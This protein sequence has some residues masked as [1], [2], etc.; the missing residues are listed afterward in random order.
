MVATSRSILVAGGAG[1]IGSHV[2]KA[3]AGRGF[4]P[5]TYDNLC[6]GNRWA[7]RWGPL[8]EGDIGDASLLGDTLRRYEI[9]GAIHLAAFA[10]VGE[11]VVAPERYFENNVSKALVFLDTLRRHGVKHLVFSST[12]ATYG[13]PERVPIVET[14][15]QRPINPYGETKL[16]V[17]R[18]LHWYRQAHDF[19]SVSLRY[20]NASGADPDG[21]IGEHHVP[22][23]HL[24]PLLVDA[25]LSGRPID[26]FGTD[27]PTRDGTCVRDYIHVT[28]LAAGHLAALRYLFADGD[29]PAFNLGVGDGHTVFEMMKYVEQASGRRVPFRAA[30]RRAGDPAALV[31]D[32]SLA[33]SVLNWTPE[34]SDPAT[35][36]R[37]A[38]R[39]HA[40]RVNEPAEQRTAGSAP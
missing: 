26:V 3:L 5:V 13:V 28:D 24:V 9:S 15:P 21:E 29:V 39:W 25:A 36:C 35:I 34:H 17:E 11:S 22:E 18:A 10:Y 8:V 40:Q 1:Y 4:L 2:A 14:N 38:W 33:R 6:T 30:P 19:H 12:C 37:T 7:V 31:A 27:H 20:F 16:F 23:T 32:N